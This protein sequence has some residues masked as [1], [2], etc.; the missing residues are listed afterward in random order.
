MSANPKRVQVAVTK[1]AKGKDIYGILDKILGQK[2]NIG[3]LDKC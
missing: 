1:G 2:R 3:K